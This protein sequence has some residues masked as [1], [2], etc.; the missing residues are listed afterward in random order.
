MIYP[1]DYRR[2]LPEIEDEVIDAVRRVLHSNRLILGPETERFESELAAFVGAAHA[3]GV[4]SGTSA[5][6]LVLMARGVG[7]GDEVITVSNTCT[8]TIAAIRGTGAVPVFV[9]VRESDLLIDPELIAPAIT[10]KTRGIVPVHLWGGSA[11]VDAIVDIAREHELF[12]VEDCAQ[13][14]GTEWNSRHVGTFG[15]AGCFSFYPTKNIGAFGD[16]GAIVTDDEELYLRLRRARIYGYDENAVSQEEG[17]NARINEIQA[18]ILRVKLARYPRWLARRV[19]IASIYDEMISHP[20]VVKPAWADACTPSFH[21]YVIRCDQRDRL[22]QWL[23]ERE[24]ATAVHYP[25]PVHLMP[26]YRFLGGESLDLPV[27]VRQA[28]RILSLPVHDAL[29]NDEARRVVTAVN[30]FAP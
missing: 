16:A 9:D 3:V 1:F 26:A 17:T 18:A 8:P 25:V 21:Q 15:D 5:L 19:E 7:H 20:A 14:Q 29:T 28:D 22:A 6:Q 30:S 23:E 2:R 4:S 24:V 12:V 13:A 10:A 11:D 27:T